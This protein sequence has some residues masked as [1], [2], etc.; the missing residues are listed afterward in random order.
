MQDLRDDVLQIWRSKRMTVGEG[1]CW[2]GSNGYPSQGGNYIG[3]LPHHFDTDEIQL[4]SG[5]NMT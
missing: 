5:N 4:K 1:S 2:G 3:H